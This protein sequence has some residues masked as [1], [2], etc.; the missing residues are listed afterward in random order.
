MNLFNGIPADDAGAFIKARRKALKLTQA[1][2]AERIGAPNNAYYSTLESGRIDFRRSTKYLPRL[3]EVLGISSAE[4][5]VH[6][7]LEYITLVSSDVQAIGNAS[8]IPLELRTLGEK[9]IREFRALAEPLIEKA[10]VKAG[11]GPSFLEEDEAG[12]IFI[13][14]EILERYPNCR[15][16][17]IE[18]D[19]MEPDYP[20]GWFAIVLPEPGLAEFGSDVLVWLSDNGRVLKRL[21]QS[22]EDGDHVLFQLKPP[23]G[24]TQVFTTPLGSRIMGVVV[25]VRRGGKPKV[26]KRVLYSAISE[27][28][29]QLLEDEEF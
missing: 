14:P 5:R 24:Q 19:C 29:P 27:F 4:A 13:E 15:V 18:G 1:Q 17:Q 3:L 10:F 16:F 25:D 9:A 11:A 8:K 28:M 2:A 26:S 20:N 22:R 21:L 12:T 6:L 23:V 7:G